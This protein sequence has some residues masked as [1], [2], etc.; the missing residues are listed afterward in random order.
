MFDIRWY[1]IVTSIDLLFLSIA[2]MISE[3][4]YFIQNIVN[5]FLISKYF[6]RIYVMSHISCCLIHHTCHLYLSFSNGWIWHFICIFK[7]FWFF[8]YI[9]P[10]R[11]KCLELAINHILQLRLLSDNFLFIHDNH[12]SFS[13]QY[14]YFAID[15]LNLLIN[16]S[17]LNL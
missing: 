9:F 13:G 8:K 1:F 3:I 12:I 10:F 15:Q 7:F 17:L 14:G 4:A 5:C 6:E 16:R 11:N 2:K